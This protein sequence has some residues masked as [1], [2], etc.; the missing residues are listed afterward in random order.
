MPYAYS[1]RRILLA[2]E[3]LRDEFSS[4]RSSFR[5]GSPIQLSD[6]QTWIVPSPPEE[7]ERNAAPFKTDYTDLIQAIIEAEGGSE[8]CL[9]E[10][11]FAIFLLDHNYSL[12]PADYQRLLDPGTS[13]WQF[14]FHEIAQEHMHVFLDRF[15]GRFEN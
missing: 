10:L 2:R 15:R 3:S 1:T 4:R 9:A 7:S 11:A 6:G 12:S 8:Q 14:A 13:D 5:S